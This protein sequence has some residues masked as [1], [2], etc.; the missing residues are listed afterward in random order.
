[1]LQG[2]Y[3]GL[4]HGLGGLCGGIIYQRKGGQIV[5]IAAGQTGFWPLCMVTL[6]PE[7]LV[8]WPEPAA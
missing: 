2:L 1:M 4:G 7:H 3:F 5:F 6:L 8:G